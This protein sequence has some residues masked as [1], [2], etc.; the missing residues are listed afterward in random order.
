[1]LFVHDSFI[2]PTT[3]EN[4]LKIVL[5]CSYNEIRCPSKL[6]KCF[7]EIQLD[8]STRRS[9]QSFSKRI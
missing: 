9:E 2:K 5:I 7:V 3:F 6:P 4:S 1:M 8:I